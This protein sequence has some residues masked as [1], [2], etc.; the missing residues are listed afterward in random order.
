MYDFKTINIVIIKHFDVAIAYH[1]ILSNNNLNLKYER[2][3]LI[4][5]VITRTSETK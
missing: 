2:H 3:N 1:S 5:S 4:P